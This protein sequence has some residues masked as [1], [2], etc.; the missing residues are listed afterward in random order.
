VI[1]VTRA[2]AYPVVSLAAELE[3]LAQLAVRVLGEHVNDHGLCVVCGVAFP[4]ES[5][6][7]AEHNTALL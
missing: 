1:A 5:A 7:L 3:H 2:D 6:V 4:C